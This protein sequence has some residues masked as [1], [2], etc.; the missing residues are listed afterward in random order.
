MIVS[1]NAG[2]HR[3][4]P[5]RPPAR[6]RA[7]RRASAGTRPANP[8]SSSMLVARRSCSCSETPTVIGEMAKS[9]GP[10]TPRSSPA[11]S[12]TRRNSASRS[13]S[14]MSASAAESPEHDRRRRGVHD[15]ARRRG[16]RPAVDQHPGPQHRVGDQPELPGADPDDRGR[17]APFGHPPRPPR[18]PAVSAV[19]DQ[20][21]A[22]DQLVDAAVARDARR[23]AR[24]VDMVSARNRA[25]SAGR[26][27]RPR[28]AARGCG[29]PW[30]PRPRPR[31]DRSTAPSAWPRSRTRRRAR[32]PRRVRA[33]SC[34][35]SF[36]S[37]C[38][39]P[40]TTTKTSSVGWRRRRG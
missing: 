35:S 17:A 6:G 40:A 1:R 16:R 29:P 27:G 5:G 2:V 23:R 3:D 36:H 10:T 21:L 33:D 26:E 39:R 18:R 8:A 32:G 24:A 34:R 31:A 28:P 15:L 12:V 14:S 19:D 37:R 30:P 9:R 13:S 25:P 22:L 7:G 11:R 4:R 38:T 20:R